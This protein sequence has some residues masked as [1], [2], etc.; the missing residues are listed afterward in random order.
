MKYRKY[1]FFNFDELQG[2]EKKEE[3]EVE[4]SIH[5]ISDLHE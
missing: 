2:Q 5:V 3:E 1:D 4:E